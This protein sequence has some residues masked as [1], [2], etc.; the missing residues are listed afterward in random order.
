MLTLYLSLCIRCSPCNCLCIWDAHPVIVSVYEMLTL[1]LYPCMR[2]SPCNYLHVWDAI[3]HPVY[4]SAYEM[5]SGSACNCLRVWDAHPVLDSVCVRGMKCSR[6]RLLTDWQTNTHTSWP[7]DGQT[8]TQADRS[9]H[10]KNIIPRGTANKQGQY[11]V[12]LLH[13]IQYNTQGIL[14]DS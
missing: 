13:S 5:L 14:L 10:I 8:G 3:A 11:S 6:R 1:Y 2:C 9:S 7:T 12:L 4:I